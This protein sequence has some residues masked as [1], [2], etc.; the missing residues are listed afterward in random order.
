VPGADQFCAPIKFGRLFSGIRGITRGGYSTAETL[1]PMDAV[2][3]ATGPTGTVPGH[4]RVHK[5]GQIARSPMCH[6]LSLQASL[7]M[8]S[9][10]AAG[11][12][13]FG[14]Q[15]LVAVWRP[16]LAHDAKLYRL[17]RKYPGDGRNRSVQ[18][19]HSWDSAWAIPGLLSLDPQRH[20]VPRLWRR[21]FNTQVWSLR[22]RCCAGINDRPDN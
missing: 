4:D 18:P 7:P 22:K 21:M 16:E 13:L 6:Q 3:D 15:V 1:A 12:G 20:M 17:S 14:F 11:I 8:R 9:G 5:P 2:G 10:R 19:H